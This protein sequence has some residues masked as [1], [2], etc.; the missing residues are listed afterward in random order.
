MLWDLSSFNTYLK[1]YLKGQTTVAR[2]AIIVSVKLL[3]RLAGFYI[4]KTML[5]TARTPPPIC[6]EQQV[7]KAP[8]TKCVQH[9]ILS[10]QGEQDWQQRLIPAERKQLPADASNSS[11]NIL[12]FTSFHSKTLP[13]SVP[14]AAG[15][16]CASMEKST[17]DRET[18]DHGCENVFSP[19]RTTRKE[20]R[21]LQGVEREQSL[22][23]VNNVHKP[24]EGDKGQSSEK[25]CF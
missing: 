3:C 15:R 24:F 7:L 20:V 14:H 11:C 12:R 23:S 19:L 21:G 4:R 9:W 8:G 1:G 25:C 22:S 18:A 5:H 10:H 13:G 16:A 6:P 2:K 17:L